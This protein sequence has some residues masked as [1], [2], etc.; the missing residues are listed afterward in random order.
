[1][2]LNRTVTTLIDAILCNGCG[3]CIH[4]CPSQTIT[5]KND[6]AMVSGHQSL[7]CDHCAAIC[8][9]EAIRV[10]AID[11]FRSSK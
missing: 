2:P 3:R 1:M 11:Q 7:G 8:P 9:T 10:T 5:M 4:V 6:K